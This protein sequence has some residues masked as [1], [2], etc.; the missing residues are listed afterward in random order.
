MKALILYPYPVE[1]DGL[2]LQG[3]YLMK[4]LK[5]LGIKVLSCDRDDS[6]QKKWA[7][8]HFKPDVA[9]GIG[10]WVDT[11]DLIIQPLKYGIKPIPWL[12]ADGWIANYQNIL[13]KLSLIVA[14]SNWV[15]STY[16]RDGVNGDNIHVCPIG[17]NPEY[18][19]PLP[20]DDPGRKKLRELLGVKE[21]E[22][23]ILT[24]GG[25]LTSKGAQE[26]FKAIAKI[27]DDIPNWKY[28]CKCMDSFS[29]RNHGK[30]ERLLI[31]ELGLD[32]NIIYLNDPFSPDFMAQ[33]LNACD[34]YAAPSRL[35]G[36]GMIQLE[37]QACG[38]PVI[39]INVGGPRDTI[40]NNKTGFL[41]DVEYE[42][43]LNSE[44]VYPH[45]GF[46]KKQV[47]EFPIPKTFAYRANIDQLAEY[48]KKLLTDDKLAEKMG[49]SA[50]EHA[51]KNFHYKVVAQKMLD[52][53][54]QNVLDKQ[55]IIQSAKKISIER[56]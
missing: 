30:E 47:I 51:F 3:Y 48:T 24:I 32:K 45:M 9:I 42:I 40:I 50:S 55:N 5:E 8:E 6:I 31:K 25:D 4:G 54:N 14:T 34:I 35:E 46:E 43:K 19:Y 16:I 13:N 27:K 38:K 33:L 20:K 12:N 18:F 21:E 26:M 36:F 53:I 56:Q 22:K 15:K 52:L 29:S 41:V 37:A 39:S 7:F 49:K 23:M 17:F 28:V 11:P 44:W 2:S 10:C 1:F